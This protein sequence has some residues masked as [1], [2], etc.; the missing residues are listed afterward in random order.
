[1]DY[2]RVRAVRVM[3]FD[4]TFNSISMI[5]CWSVLFVEETGVARESHKTRQTLSH[6]VVSVYGRD[7]IL[8]IKLYYT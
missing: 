3:I 4:A 7:A 1:M 2:G 8:S 6:N 5:S